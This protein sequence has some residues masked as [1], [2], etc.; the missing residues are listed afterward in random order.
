[1]VVVRA[2]EAFS[3]DPYSAFSL[4]NRNGVENIAGSV[5][6][7]YFADYPFLHDG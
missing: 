1:V 6:V 7:V 4:R 3:L 2:L 5:S